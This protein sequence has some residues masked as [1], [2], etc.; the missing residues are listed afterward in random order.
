M[1]AKQ[2]VGHSVVENRSGLVVSEHDTRSEALAEA[3]RRN[4]V[5]PLGRFVAC[6]WGDVVVPSEGR[7][8]LCGESGPH[9]HPRDEL[10]EDVDWVRWGSDE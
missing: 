8:D 6:R 9:E 4:A 1:T 10:Y 7:C 3:A 2:P 5:D